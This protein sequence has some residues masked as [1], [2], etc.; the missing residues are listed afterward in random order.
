MTL[1]EAFKVA[2][3]ETAHPIRFTPE[4]A[5]EWSEAEAALIAAGYCPY[6]ACNDLHVKLLDWQDGNY[7][8]HA[9]RECPDCEQFVICGEQPEYCHDGW[10]GDYDPGL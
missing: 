6:C 8:E 10:R 2:V 3:K 7:W 5:K 9:G 4:E 1:S